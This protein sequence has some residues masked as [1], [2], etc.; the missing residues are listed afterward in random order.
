LFNNIGRT[1]SMCQALEQH[2]IRAIT[3]LNYY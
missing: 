3:K 1:I 2:P